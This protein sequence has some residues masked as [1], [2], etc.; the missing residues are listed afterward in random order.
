MVCSFSRYIMF[1]LVGSSSY[2]QWLW[3]R[4][5]SDLFGLV[6]V[7][8]KEAIKENA[9]KTQVSTAVNHSLAHNT[10]PVS[11][12]HEGVCWVM[13]R[14][15]CNPMISSFCASDSSIVVIVI[16]WQ[17]I[18]RRLADVFARR[19]SCR[20]VKQHLKGLTILDNTL[21]RVY[22]DRVYTKSILSFYLNDTLRKPT[23]VS[24]W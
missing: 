8:R 9:V 18:S 13:R 20:W 1:R 12:R 17:R 6:Y 11:V 15:W 16:H 19:T 24:W 5:W 10:I 2:F 21:Q 22:F 4:G 23:L 3:C 14:Y 7:S